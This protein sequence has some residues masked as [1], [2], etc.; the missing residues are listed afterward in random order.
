MAK[1]KQEKLQDKYKVHKEDTGSTQVQ[2]VGLTKRINE[3]TK[4]LKDHKKDFDSRVGL[5]KI[6]GKR[7]RL[8]SYLKKEDEKKYLKLIKDLSLRK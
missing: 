3:L 6:I 5:L 8:L 4:H 2:I 7:R 1:T